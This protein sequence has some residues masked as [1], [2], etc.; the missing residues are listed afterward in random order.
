[1]RSY[2][3]FETMALREQLE[4]AATIA[5]LNFSRIL[6][7]D[8]VYAL[9]KKSYVNLSEDLVRKYPA[10]WFWMHNRRGLP[11]VK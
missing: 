10:P 8:A 6:P 3:G 7:E 4:Y 2:N 9:V 1:M 11:K 5:I